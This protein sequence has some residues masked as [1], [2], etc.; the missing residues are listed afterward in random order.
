MFLFFCKFSFSFVNI[1]KLLISS[2][3]RL[4]ISIPVKYQSVNGLQICRK[5]IALVVLQNK[6]MN[7]NNFI[8]SSERVQ[9][10]LSS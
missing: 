8:S 7:E 6:Q 2:S 1:N 10:N 5:S 3:I 4:F 9:L